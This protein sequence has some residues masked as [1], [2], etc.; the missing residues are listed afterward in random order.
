MSVALALLAT[1][2]VLALYAYGLYPL[3][4]RLLARAPAQPAAPAGEEWPPV[5]IVV[6]VF[7]EEA[8]LRETL[9]GLLALDYPADRRHVLVVSDA[10]TDAS[11][12]IAAEFADRGVELLRLG[13]RRGKTVAENAAGAR[14]RGEIVVNVDA[15][16]RLPP[17]ALK[18]LVA[19]FRDPTVGVASGRDVS[20]SRH[21][22]DA[23]AGESSYV[24]YEMWVREL[25]TRAGGIVGASG[26]FYAM[27]APLYKEWVPTGLSRDFASALIAREHGYRAVSVPQ[28]VCL[29]PRTGSVTREY[30]RKV[31][32]MARGMATLWYKRRLLDVRRYGQFAV[33]LWSHKVCRWVVPWG[34]VASVVGAALLAATPAGAW[35]LLGVG[36][37]SA[38]LGAGLVSW[39]ATGALPKALAFVLAVV[40]A[41]VAALHATVR[42][43]LKR[44]DAIWEPTR[45]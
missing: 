6:P 24:G 11:D 44:G 10:S 16:V 40:A 39:H 18:V 8:V 4:L 29:V 43:A 36:L 25:E 17:G 34:A 22:V 13:R 41:N 12:A 21:G 15:S 35:V 20:V 27:R 5:T 7:N 14:V 42:V 33:M 2:P 45:R 32:T 9:A 31:R 3:L 23:N 1:G 30:R 28:A 19:S 26:C 38:A 37:G